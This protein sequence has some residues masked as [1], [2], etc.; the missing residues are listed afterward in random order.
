MA[1]LCLYLDQ[2]KWR[3]SRRCTAT[4]AVAHSVVAL[5]IALFVS[6][7]AG[8]A[9]PVASRSIAEVDAAGQGGQDG[10]WGVEHGKNS[11]AGKAERDGG[12][13][14]KTSDSRGGGK[15]GAGYISGAGRD[16]VLCCNCYH[17]HYHVLL[18]LVDTPMPS[19]PCACRRLHV[20]ILGCHF[21]GCFTALSAAVTPHHVQPPGHVHSLDHVQPPGHVQLLNL[22]QSP[23]HVQSPS[24]VQPPATLFPVL[25]FH[26]VSGAGSAA[27]PVLAM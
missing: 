22:V 3:P 14:A 26:C 15:S 23:A 2:T 16:E 13:P 20:T 11:G 25:T 9:T 24:H 4:V 10:V 5:L 1:P 27:L 12:V 6:L 17:C 19:L 21:L 8:V 18:M 7:R